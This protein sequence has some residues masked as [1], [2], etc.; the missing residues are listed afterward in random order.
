MTQ[1]NIDTMD[2]IVN[3]LVAGK[4]LS[5]ALKAVYI[6]RI[7]AIPFNDRTF[8]VAVTELDIA[9]RSINALRRAGISTLNDVIRFAQDNRIT[10]IQNFG[11][12]GG[13]ELYEAMLDYGWKNMTSNERVDFLIDI[14][15]RNEI[16]CK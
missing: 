12:N 4:K 1:K 6:K 9:K 5:E 14:V 16:Y 15:E 3:E 10:D 2:C 8:D 7:V 11:V 13:I